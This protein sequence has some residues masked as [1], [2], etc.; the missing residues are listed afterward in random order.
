[1]MKLTRT[2]LAAVLM[3]MTVAVVPAIAQAQTFDDPEYDLTLSARGPAPARLYA[4]YIDIKSVSVS[5]LSD[6]SYVFTMQLYEI[7][8]QVPLNPANG[9]PVVAIRYFWRL[10]DSAG[11]HVLD[12]RITWIE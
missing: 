10:R 1:M 7:I 4:G 9:K 11:N 2:L 12:V 8:P 3:I 6:G 5:K